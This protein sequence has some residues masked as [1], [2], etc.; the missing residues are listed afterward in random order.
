AADPRGRSALWGSDGP[1][2]TGS[3]RCCEESFR[4][5]PRGRR[6]RRARARTAR[7]TSTARAASVRSVG[8]SS[9]TA[10]SRLLLSLSKL[11]EPLNLS[12]LPEQHGTE[13]DRVV[14]A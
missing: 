12:K 3:T 10:G 7:A 11:P 13:G 4:V 6:T 14:H 5:A 1:A 2:R 9:P 8:R